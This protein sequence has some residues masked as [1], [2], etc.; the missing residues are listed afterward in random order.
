MNNKR[1]NYKEMSNNW[2]DETVQKIISIIRHHIDNKLQFS[3]VRYGDGEADLIKNT[4]LT[5]V[6]LSRFMNW[7]KYTPSEDYFLKFQQNF[8]EACSHSDVNVFQTSKVEGW[9]SEWFYNHMCNNII[10]KKSITIPVRVTNKLFGNIGGTSPS[11][12]H[13]IIKPGED[14]VLITCR[15]ESKKAIQSLT[16]ANIRK[17]ILI[18]S[19]ASFRKKFKDNDKTS[20]L[21]DRINQIINNEIPKYI[22]PGTIVLIGSGPTKPMYC[23]AIKKHGGIALDL[24]SSLDGISGYC[25]RGKNKGTKVQ[26][27]K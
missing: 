19:E 11:L 27:L 26:K 17:I 6:I 22:K 2:S 12:L 14:V 18:P 4:K 20:Q 21:P 24:G 3:L 7:F 10:D 9:A 16:G 13:K 5:R 8:K 1:M 25:T 15:L 23:A